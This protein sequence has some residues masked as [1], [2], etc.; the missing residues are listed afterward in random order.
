M[1]GRNTCLGVFSAWG[2][3][4]HKADTYD[5]SVNFQC[6]F[7]LMYASDQFSKFNHLYW[8]ALHIFWQILLMLV[9]P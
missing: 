9:I 1:V 6:V 5:L 2:S 4:S 8:R 7:I 3:S